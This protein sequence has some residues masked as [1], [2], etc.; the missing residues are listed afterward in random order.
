[1]T[2]LTKIV[3]AHKGRVVESTEEATHLV[4]WDEE[5]D[6]KNRHMGE[7]I[8]D[9]NEEDYIRTLQ[10]RPFSKNDGD[11]M[12]NGGVALV[13][14]WYHP[15]SYDE[16]IPLKGEDIQ[17]TDPPDTHLMPQG[18]KWRVCCKF[19][20][21]VAIYNEW[22]NELDYEIEKRDEI[23]PGL[24]ITSPASKRI[25]KKQAARQSEN[26]L[27]EY[28]VGSLLFTEKMNQN[29]VPTTEDANVES[30]K[31]AEV[32]VDVT[33]QTNKVSF[34]SIK[35]KGSSERKRKH[36]DEGNDTKI[37][38]STS[39]QTSPPE[40]F[41]NT[42]VHVN[43]IKAMSEFFDQ[44][45]TLR[46]PSAYMRIRNVIFELYRYNPSVYLTATEARKKISGDVCTIIHVHRFMDAHG[47][48]NYA[49]K[50]PRPIS[51]NYKTLITIPSQLRGSTQHSHEFD[52]V[53]SVAEDEHKPLY[54]RSLREITGSDLF[55]SG[56]EMELRL[57]SK[58]SDKLLTAV[59]V[60]SRRSEQ[61]IE[62]DSNHDVIK[63]SEE[64]ADELCKDIAKESAA[65]LLDHVRAATRRVDLIDKI[66]DDMEAERVS[67]KM[68]SSD[69]T[70]QQI[71]INRGYRL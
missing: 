25:K 66:E 40:W 2:E 31:V 64:Y 37:G 56:K 17:F 9:P 22:G 41:S 71:R 26:P 14:W 55:M 10:L 21:D 27:Q 6:G 12:D 63:H 1:M 28:V 11:D 65:T 67:L 20:S 57:S 39:N 4:E 69:L 61:Q 49:C 38:E 44:S 70:Q 68:E 46:T 8:R 24:E 54:Q 13:H 30:V 36:I 5:V 3:L 29:V 47:I 15:D 23:D 45:C 19:I 52:G 53:D 34:K 16:Y 43:E 60:V 35:P 48:I 33:D 42:S 58:F 51:T 7:L 62:D 32:E 59:G 50:G 18:R